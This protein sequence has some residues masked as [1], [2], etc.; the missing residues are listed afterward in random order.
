M[1]SRDACTSAG[2]MDTVD[3][4]IALKLLGTSAGTTA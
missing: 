4:G 2:R 1:A 3:A